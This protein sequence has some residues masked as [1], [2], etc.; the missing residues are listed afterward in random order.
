MRKKMPKEKITIAPE[1]EHTGA[2]I[3]DKREIE[4]M[5]Q[6]FRESMQVFRAK[7]TNP[8]EKSRTPRP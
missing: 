8:S 5:T 2:L 6:R 7:Q 3:P 1:K 4:K